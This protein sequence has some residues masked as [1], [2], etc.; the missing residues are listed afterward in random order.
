[1]AI[2]FDPY[3]DESFTGWGEVDY[4]LHKDT[5][6]IASTIGYW[7]N[8]EYEGTTEQFSSSVFVSEFFKNQLNEMDERKIIC[9]DGAIDT[10]D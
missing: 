2:L 6:F 3:K 7:S 8:L 9:T 4:K 5:K 1:M 10:L